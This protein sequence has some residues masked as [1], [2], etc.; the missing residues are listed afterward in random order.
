MTAKDAL[1]DNDACAA[2]RLDRADDEQVV[3][4]LRRTTIFY[5]EVGD[6]PCAFAAL[7]RRP[8]VDPGEA[9]HVGPGAFHVA[10]IIG[11]IDDP[12]QVGVFEIDPRPIMMR[13]PDEGAGDEGGRNVNHC[14]DR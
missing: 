7:H 13:G 10:Q 14:S 8:L 4:E 2:H 5:G 12:R 3:V 9:Q 6:R 11:V 1:R